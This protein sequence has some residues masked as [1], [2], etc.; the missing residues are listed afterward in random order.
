M[1]GLGKLQAEQH[2]QQEPGHLLVA[3][4]PA[5][6]VHRHDALRNDAPLSGGHRPDDDRSVSVSVLR[7]GGICDGLMQRP[8]AAATGR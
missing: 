2:G 8:A 7:R 4:A 5:D 6:R 3:H 1:Q